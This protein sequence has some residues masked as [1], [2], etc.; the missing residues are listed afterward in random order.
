[1]PKYNHQP[2]CEKSVSYQPYAEGAGSPSYITTLLCRSFWWGPIFTPWCYV[3]TIIIH[4]DDTSLATIRPYKR[5]A[6]GGDT[7]LATI[8]FWWR[9]LVG[10]QVPLSSLVAWSAALEKPKGTLPVVWVIYRIWFS[11]KTIGYE[12]EPFFCAMSN[13]ALKNIWSDRKLIKV[14]AHAIRGA[15]RDVTSSVFLSLQLFFLS[16][17]G[18]G[19]TKP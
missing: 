17:K 4:G 9:Y 19:S 3:L 18:R 2:R 12:R 11:I 7:S 16:N 13:F 6:S 14:T 10:Y 5:Y 15:K 1:M 8:I